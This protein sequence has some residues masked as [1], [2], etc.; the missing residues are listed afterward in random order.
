MGSWCLAV[1]RVPDCDSSVSAERIATTERL[2]AVYRAFDPQPLLPEDH[3]LYVSLDEVRGTTGIVDRLAT[4]IRLADRPTCQILAGHRG[5]GK[6]TELRRL[7]HQLEHEEPKHFVVF[8]DVDSDLDRYDIDFPDILISVV[9]QIAAQLRERIQI[10]L[11]PGFFAE[12]LQRLAKVLGTEFTLEGVEFD[13]GLL[14]VSAAMKHSPD[15]RL[16]VRKLLEPDTTNLLDAANDVIG[17]AKLEL[18]KHGYADLVVVVDDLDKMAAWQRAETRRSAAEH[19]FIDREGQ[20]SGFE[21]HLVY[22]MPLELAYSVRERTVAN[23]YGGPVPVI[24]M[25]RIRNRPP[26]SGVHEPGMQLFRDV[27]AARLQK[28][29]AKETDIFAEGV[30][31]ELIRLSGGQPSELII[32]IR[33]ALVGGALPISGD[34]VARAAREGRRAYARQLRAEHWPVIQQVRKDGAFTRNADNDETIRDL[35]ESRAILQY[36]TEEEWYADNPLM[37][38]LE[39][40]AANDATA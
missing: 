40:P 36:R 19:L 28:A 13:A 2:Q 25:T 35:L 24:P 16:E 32:L 7:Q 3:D 31:D 10:S 34:A 6:S 23:L 14:K 37:S 8:F 18:R 4:R 17:Q 38:G 1:C 22:T 9:R 20:L 39:V 30:R 29:G 26:R 33:E 11:K 5:S 12:R 27:I 21:C 15:A